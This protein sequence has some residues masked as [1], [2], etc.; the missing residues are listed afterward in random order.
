M[1]AGLIGSPLGHSRSP[2]MQQAAFDALGIGARYELW[3]TPLE[4][5]RERVAGMRAPETLGANVTIPHKTAVMPLLD[6]VTLEAFRVGAVN[7]V[8][9]EVRANGSVRLMGHNTDFTALR[10]VLRE[11]DAWAVTA[12]RPHMLVLGAGGAA[13]AALTVARL[14]GADV[15]VAA[16]RVEAARSVLASVWR[17]THVGDAPDEGHESGIQGAPEE[18]LARAVPLDGDS[19]PLRDALAETTVLVNATP[20]GTRDPL[21][22]PLTDDLLE[23]LPSGAFVFDM[24][25]NP[26]ETALV[27]AAQVRGLRA[28]GGLAMLLYQGA[29]AFSL[30]TRQPAPLDVMR[31]ALE[32]G[33]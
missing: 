15:S 7:T 8:V 17:R 4:R 10:R 5:L 28:S 27:R 2:A 33:V 12:G 23:Q 16:R 32:R 19:P 24:V 1:L 14:E 13:L 29:E 25:Y 6:A 11:Q 20:I 22:S 31:A 9:R 26:P 3:E 21:A 30:W 18:W